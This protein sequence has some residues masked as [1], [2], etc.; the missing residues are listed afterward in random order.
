MTII[1]THITRLICPVCAGLL[2]GIVAVWIALAV[3]L[4]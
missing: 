3:V 2:I 4:S 1:A